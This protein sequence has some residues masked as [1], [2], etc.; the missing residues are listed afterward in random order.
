[1]KNKQRKVKNMAA[2]ELN[3]EIRVSVNDVDSTDKD[4]ND[5]KK[6]INAFIKK[7]FY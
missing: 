5:I 6:K 2:K 3:I 1:V 7:T 4:F